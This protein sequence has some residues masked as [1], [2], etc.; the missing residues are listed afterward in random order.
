MASR[1]CVLRKVENTLASSSSGTP[2]GRA[3][4]SSSAPR[5]GGLSPP[6]SPSLD[7]SPTTSCW[8]SAASSMPPRV[9]LRYPVCFR[10]SLCCAASASLADRKE[11]ASMRGTGLAGRCGS[12]PGAPPGCLVLLLGPAPSAS[13][14]LGFSLC[15]AASSPGGFEYMNDTLCRSEYLFRSASFRKELFISRFCSS[16][17]SLCACWLVFASLKARSSASNL[18]FW[19]R[20]DSGCQ[21]FWL[22]KLWLH[23]APTPLGL[24]VSPVSFARCASALIPAS[25]PREGA[26]DDMLLLRPRRDD[27]RPEG[28]EG[29]SIHEAR[30]IHLARG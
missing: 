12:L 6:L 25:T 16:S 27:L 30:G 11:A 19:L 9:G 4:A 3:S 8:F 26:R 5:G 17:N 15:R 29:R 28:S 10:S 13:P 21:G 2:P 20:N 7:D 14:S 22:R 23:A 18:A 1:S 24:Y